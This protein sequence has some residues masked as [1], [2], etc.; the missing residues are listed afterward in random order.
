MGREDCLVADREVYPKEQTPALQLIRPTSLT[1]ALASDTNRLQAV[2]PIG[3]PGPKTL[4]PTPT[5][6]L[7]LRSHRK[8]ACRSSTTGAAGADWGHP[9]GDARSEGTRGEHRRQRISQ[10][11]IPGTIPYTPTGTVLHNRPDTNNIVGADICVY[12]IV[13]AIGLP[14][15]KK[16]PTCLWASIVGARIHHTWYTW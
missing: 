13:G 16:P 3:R 8:P 12:S 4:L 10:T 2:S 6:R 9:I 5:P 1:G 14:Y 11:M 7:R 15:G